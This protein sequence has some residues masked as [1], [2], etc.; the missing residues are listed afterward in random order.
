MGRLTLRKLAKNYKNIVY[1]LQKIY[2]RSI[3]NNDYTNFI[4]ISNSG[5]DDILK[6]RNVLN[7]AKAYYQKNK[8][9]G[10]VNFF[11]QLIYQNKFARQSYQEENDVI[12]KKLHNTKK[13]SIYLDQE[14]IPIG[15]RGGLEITKNQSVAQSFSITKDGRLVAMDII[16]IKQHRCTPTKS[17]YVSLVKIE[18]GKLNAETYYTRELHANEISSTVKLIFGSDAPQVKVGEKYAIY[19]QTDA[20]P[21]G[22]TYAWG[23]GIDTYNDGE[24]FIN[25]RPNIRDMKFRT[26]IS[27]N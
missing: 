16:D 25:Q 23:G 22:C 13:S 26:Y 8:D 4:K 10:A 3:N 5:I 12:L 11:N 7:K 15:S 14:N 17:L 9:K 2:L 27:E 1:S 20:E 24:T 21:G 6:S 18:D 19:L